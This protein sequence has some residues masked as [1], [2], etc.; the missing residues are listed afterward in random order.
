MSTPI[1][2]LML[3]YPGAGKTTVAKTVKEITGATHI[4]ED[5]YRK[6]LFPELT[7]SDEEN[8]KL[9]TYLNKMTAQLLVQGNDVVYDTSFNRYEDRLRMYEIARS[10]GAGFKLIWVQTPKQLAHERATKNA[11][12]QN[13][14]PLAQL[15]GDM[16]DAT[17]QRL[18]NKLESPRRNEPTIEIDGTRVTQE[19]IQQ[20]LRKD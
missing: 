16:D 3:G 14:R 17:F 2:Y 7:F 19:Y 13:T 4:W 18:S 1:L 11:A 8:L 12:Q 10:S 20:S 6:K 5:Y 15:L 9:H